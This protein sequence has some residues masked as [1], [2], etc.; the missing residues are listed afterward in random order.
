LLAPLVTGWLLCW[1]FS[2][3]HLADYPIAVAS[4]F[5]ASTAPVRHRMKTTSELCDA[6]SVNQ[7]SAIQETAVTVTGKGNIRSKVKINKP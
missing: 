6:L 4:G 7:G 5:I 1:L 3:G 2:S